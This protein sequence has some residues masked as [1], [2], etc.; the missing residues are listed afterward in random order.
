VRAIRANLPVAGAICAF[1]AI[2][3]V[4]AAYILDHQRLR[5]PW[6]DV[7]RIEAEFSTGQAVSPGQG[8]SVTVAGVKVGEIGRVW[9]EEGRALLRLDLEPGAV[10][11]Y[12]DA[13]LAL[14]PKT[15]LNDMSVQ[16]D[17]GT[18]GTGR[19]EDGDRIGI[20]R[21]E[22]NVNPDEVLG[23]LDADTRRYL[24]LAV[25]A[26]GQGLRNRGEGLRALLRSSQ[27]TLEQG[28]RVAGAV[29]DR[30][31]KL[32][33]LVTNLHRLSAAAAEKDD[34][35]ARLVTAASATVGTLAEREA[36]LGAA[37]ERMP[38]AL[39][40]TRGALA[41]VRALA[42]EA[43]PALDELRPAARELDPA[44]EGVRPL[45]R[46]ARP[47][48][49]D[50][51]RPLVREAG[52]LLAELRPA[53]GDLNAVTPPLQRVGRVLNHVA[54]ELGYNPPGREEGYLFWLAWFSHNANSILSIEDAH[55]VA[56]RG[57]VQV[58]CSSI[59]DIAGTARYFELLRRLPLCPK[60]AEE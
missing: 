57:L 53:L 20:G 36:E 18:P 58:G 41:D 34:D 60:G 24:Q 9:L 38:S 13:R 31:R 59:G 56:W 33:R 23:A 43:A 16:L 1:M 52:P 29:A 39:S 12:R 19:V 55:G 42:V 28:A 8:Q 46:D 14:K 10:D 49:R 32:R 54:N 5:W 35:L 26:G 4:V 7:V 11:V 47:I 21:T 44:L 37:V 40:A 27:P 25:G 17:P 51:L 2:A 6:E 22:V 15:G 45:L 50:D 3:A 30:R 48:L